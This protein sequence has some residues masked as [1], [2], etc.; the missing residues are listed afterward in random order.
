MDGSGAFGDQ[1]MMLVSL[2]VA[3]E[4]VGRD[5]R[6]VQRWVQQGRVTAYD[7]GTGQRLVELRQVIAVEADVRMRHRNKQEQRLR[8]W[9]TGEID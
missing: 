9:L 1:T 5:V 4:R 7:H 6:T 8:E 2:P 3:A